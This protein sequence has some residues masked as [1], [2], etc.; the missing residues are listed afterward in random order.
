MRILRILFGIISL[1]LLAIVTISAFV[2]LLLV[3]TFSRGR[4]G[5]VAAHK[6]ARA[7]S[8]LCLLCTCIRLKVKGR[9]KIDPRRTYVFVANHQSQLDRSEEHTSEIQSHSFI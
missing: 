5:M 7:W 9:E 3:L 8:L 2:A 1:T 4:K 6:V